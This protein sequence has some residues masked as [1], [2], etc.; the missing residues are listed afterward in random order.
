MNTSRP[1]ADGRVKSVAFDE[2]AIHVVLMDGRRV[3]APLAWYPRLEGQRRNSGSGGFHAGEVMEC[4]GKS[5]MR[6]SVPRCYC[7]SI[8]RQKYTS[9]GVAT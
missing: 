4:I 6:T 8:H 2:V 3:S 9:L 7:A 1:E 5:W